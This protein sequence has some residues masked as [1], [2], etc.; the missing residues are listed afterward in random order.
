LRSL[1][2]KL[3]IDIGPFFLAGRGGSLNP[4]EIY[5]Y[6]MNFNLSPRGILLMKFGE[7]KFFIL[8]NELLCLGITLFLLRWVQGSYF[9]LP[10]ILQARGPG[11]LRP[12][13]RAV[14]SEKK[15]TVSPD[16]LLFPT[17]GADMVDAA[18]V[19]A[20]P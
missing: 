14:S 8:H 1:A 11:L 18:D 6:C 12:R 17:M 4:L 3:L 16:I 5:R 20:L 19:A 2:P 9:I 7:I 10:L 15:F 13:E